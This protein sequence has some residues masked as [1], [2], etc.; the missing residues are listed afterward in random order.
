MIRKIRNK[1][2][3]KEAVQWTGDNIEEIFA[4]TGSSEIGNDLLEDYLEIKTLNGVVK[5]N[6]NEWVIKGVRGELY[7]CRNDI[8]EQSYEFVD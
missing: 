2:T 1:T 7:P 3:E 8:F 5:V 4:F 6:V